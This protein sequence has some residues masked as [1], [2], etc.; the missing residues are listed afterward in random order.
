MSTAYGLKLDPDRRVGNL[1]VGERQRVEIV[2]CLLQEPKLLI[3]DE[4]TSVLTPQEIEVLF[5]TLRRLVSE[6]CSILYISHKLEEIRALCDRATILRGGK[7]VGTLRPAA[8]DRAQPGRDDDRRHARRRRS[9]SR[10]PIGPVRLKV[11]GLT[12]A[13]DEQFGVDL[14][15]CQP[16]GEGRR[17]PGHR[18]RRRQR[19]VRADGGA[20]RRA[21][22]RHGRRHRASTASPSARRGPVARRA[23]GMC[24][25]PEE[26]LGHA[27]VPDMSLWEN[28]VLTATP[29]MELGRLGFI[30]VPQGQELRRQGRGRLRRAHAGRRQR[31]AQPLGRQPAEVRDRPRDAAGARRC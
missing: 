19:P 17:D 12:L 7:V 29:R 31:R 10:A 30:G 25:V 21:A 9:A 26:R 18:R 27:S 5:A 13:S 24:F 8:G 4:P 16:R 14:E 1:S 22:R 23:L 6:G 11:S 2:R 20:D 28:A 3:M 15:G